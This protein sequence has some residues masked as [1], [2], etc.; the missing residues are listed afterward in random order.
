MVLGISSGTILPS[1][2]GEKVPEEWKGISQVL[3]PV[4]LGVQKSLV[5]LE[6]PC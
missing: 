5:D 3:H 2:V 6:G 1:N 4:S